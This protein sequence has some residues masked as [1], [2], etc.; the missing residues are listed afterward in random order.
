MI[1][2]SQWK[3]IHWT[4]E[5]IEVLGTYYNG[6]GPANSVNV[7]FYSDS[8]G[9]PDTIFAGRLDLVPAAGLLT[10]SFFIIFPSRVTLPANTYWLSVQC[11]MDSATG[12]Q[13][14]WTEQL[15]SNQ[16]S[17]W[18]NPGG[19]WGT[20][21]TSWGYRVTNCNVGAA[22]FSDLSFRLNGYKGD[23]CPV[24]TASNPSPANDSTGT[25]INDV[26][27]EWTNGSGTMNVEVWFGPNERLLKV[28]D[29]SAI[30]SWPLGTLSNGTQYRW[31][32]VCKDD[33]CGIQGPDWRF[34][35][36]Q[37]TNIIVDTIDVYPQNLNNWTGTCNGASKTQISLVHGFDT[38]VGWMTFDISDIP[39]TVKINSVTFNGY[40]YDNSWP[41]WSITPMGSVNPVTDAASLIFNQVSSNYGQGVAYS[42]NIESGTLNNNWITRALRKWCSNSIC[43]MH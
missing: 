14:G 17:T 18:Q 25:P 11:N 6:T 7:W 33:N 32:I 40:L 26:S 5:S 29:G 16:E 4:I 27:L 3:M 1:S 42:Y 12:G 41:Y 34:T 43:K 36:M 30:T 23:P 35:T 13:W 19:G 10:G 21:C 2:L 37:D 9:L 22:P 24:Q 38:E 31:Y 8:G 15:D 39:D 20:A 28:Y